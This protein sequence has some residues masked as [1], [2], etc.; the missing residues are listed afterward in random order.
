MKEFVRL[1]LHLNHRRK[2]KD[3]C[4]EK[5]GI[6]GTRKKRKLRERRKDEGAEKYL[7]SMNRRDRK[8][9]TRWKVQKNNIFKN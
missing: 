7:E 2:N 1:P 9:K 5:S 4:G 3:L 6:K 8:K